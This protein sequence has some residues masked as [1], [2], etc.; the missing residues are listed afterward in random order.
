MANQESISRDLVFPALVMGISCVVVGFLPI[1]GIIGAGTPIAVHFAALSVCVGFAIMLGAFGTRA[2]IHQAAWTIVG[3][4]A[5][6]I[7]LFG[8]L[9]YRLNLGSQ[10]SAEYA[11]IFL[12]LPLYA[13]LM[14]IPCMN[15]WIRQ[16][17]QCNS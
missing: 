3:P 10:N 6:A 13:L 2:H 9:E 15:I 17:D 7:L 8:I 14:I 1:L 5:V 16:R 11:E 4:G 12:K